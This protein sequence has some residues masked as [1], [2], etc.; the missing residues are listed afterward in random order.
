MCFPLFL[1]ILQLY[2]HHIFP[3]YAPL[4]LFV[5]RFI[6][7]TYGL[8]YTTLLIYSILLYSAI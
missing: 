1:Q 7:F 2:P 3:L 4:P 5:K 8:R 6:T